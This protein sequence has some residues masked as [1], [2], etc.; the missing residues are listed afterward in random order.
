MAGSK[1]KRFRVLLI[2]DDWRGHANTVLD[3]INAFRRL[4]RHDV[5]TFNPV[6]M[7]DSVA[8]EL[9]EFDVVVI[10]YSLVLPSESYVS[11]GFRD[12]LRR[13][14]GLKIQFI[15]DEYR[16]VDRATAAARDV[17]VDVLFTCAPEPAAGQ[18]YDTGLPGVKRVQTLTGYVPMSLQDRPRRPLRERSTDVG[19]RGRDLPFWLGRLTQEKAWIGQGFLERAPRY[20]LRVDIGWREGDRVYGRGWIDLISSCRA[21]LGTESGASIADFDGS[22][23]QAVR[24]YLSEHPGAQ[25]EEVYEALLRPYEGNVVVNVIS[26][27]VFEAAALGTALVM[28]PGSYSGIVSP[29]EH[30]IVLE[31]DF[32][33]MDEVVSR[34]KDDASMTALTN[35]AYD[36]L[37]ASRRWSYAA[38]IKEFD[39]VVSEHATLVRRGLFASRQRIARVE[40]M[41]RVPPIHHRV[42][43]GVLKATSGVTGRQL[44]AGSETRMGAMLNTW[45]FALRTTLADR[46]LRQMYLE[47]SRSGMSRDRLLEELLKLSLLRRA[48]RGELRALDKFTVTSEFDEANGSLRF[49]SRPDPCVQPIGEPSGTLRSALVAGAVRAIEWDHSAVGETVRLRKPRVDLRIGQDGHKNFDLVAQIGRRKPALLERALAPVIRVPNLPARLLG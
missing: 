7:P 9:D 2:C 49:V 5:R 21:T 1:E 47:G 3:H 10:H 20:G 45:T 8:L 14:R 15:Q 4:S 48:A 36:H 22:V 19:Y 28:F 17:G 35:R 18:L 31:K 25:Y 16:W 32:S 46:Q 43:R 40:R 39:N 12:K 38:F 30:Y 6:G 42:I 24:T 34:L 29:G 27:R 44:A 26:P 37:V 13:Y 33:N 41:L 11:R 23:E